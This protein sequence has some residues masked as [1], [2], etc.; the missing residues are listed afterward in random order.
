MGF[1]CI[2]SILAGALMYFARPTGALC[3]V[4]LL[5]QSTRETVRKQYVFKLADKAIKAATVERE[6]LPSSSQRLS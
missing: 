3:K 5:S 1:G 6:W 4:V 2:L